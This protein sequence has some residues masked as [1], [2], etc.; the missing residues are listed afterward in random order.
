MIKACPRAIKGED[1]RSC[2][3]FGAKTELEELGSII[4]AL[5]NNLEKREH[6]ALVI[7]KGDLTNEV[8]I[9]SDKDT[10]GVE[11]DAR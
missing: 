2:E 4:T 9:A 6:L 7:A 8:D 10:L 1:C 11:N 5:S 3:L